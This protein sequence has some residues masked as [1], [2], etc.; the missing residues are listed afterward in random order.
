M[1]VQG[2]RLSA[3][4][5]RGGARRGWRAELLRELRRIFRR[6]LDSEGACEGFAQGFSACCGG[7]RRGCGSASGWG[8]S[9]SGAL[10]FVTLHVPARISLSTKPLGAGCCRLL[11]H[12]VAYMFSNKNILNPSI[13]LRH[14]HQ[15]S[16]DMCAHRPA[17]RAHAHAPG[18]WRAPQRRG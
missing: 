15:A 10:G 16:R 8:G 1:R 14:P 5:A 2:F 7:V 12:L 6:K 3:L 11:L 13:V 9:L 17:R 18:G 4:L